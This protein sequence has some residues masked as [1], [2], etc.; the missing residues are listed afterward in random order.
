MM[1]VVYEATPRQAIFHSAPEMY[2]LYGGAMGGG[3]S[4]ALCAE[5]I[6]LSHDYPG[7]R[8]YICRDT[9]TAFKKTTFLVLDKMLQE[10]GC[11]AKHHQTENYY[12]LRNGSTIYYG[13]LGDDVR[14]IERLKS[15]E[16]GWFAIDEASETSENF[17]LMLASRLR[18]AIP[19]IKYYG[20]LGSNPAPGWLKHR[21]IDQKLDNHIFVPALPSDNP[22]LPEGYI[23]RLLEVFP[24]EWQDRFVRGDWTA[25]EGTNNV[26]PF[27]AIQEAMQREMKVTLPREI[28]VDVA[29]Y[30][31]DES[32][33]ALRSG[34]HAE[35]RKAIRKSSTMEVAGE[36]IKEIKTSKP[37]KTKIDADGLGAGVIDRLREQGYSISEIHGGGKAQNKEKFANFKAEIYWG[38]RERLVAGDV[39]LPDD[40]ELQAQLTSCT[41]RVKSSGQLEITPKEEMKKAG[42]K[43]PDRAEAIIY[44]F[45]KPAGFAFALSSEDFY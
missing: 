45:A 7:N 42:L 38:F 14:S 15:M 16:I 8:G 25:F 39:D 22:K 9:L 33:I 26:F 3:K 19:G 2:K 13:G 24:Q 4:W 20:L 35:I 23:E 17:F 28:G 12:L 11:V 40:L 29:R 31:D 36:V 10:S 21:F 43:S 34:G 37:D 30:G 27:Q 41:Y 1:N 5:A 6:A 18:L 44:A 32:V